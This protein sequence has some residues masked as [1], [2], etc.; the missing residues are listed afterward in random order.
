[1]GLLYLYLYQNRKTIAPPR[2]RL[3]TVRSVPFELFI[4]AAGIDKVVVMQQRIYICN[5]LC[6]LRQE[7]DN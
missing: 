7:F 5:V 1:M 3:H 6:E 2:N 4:Q